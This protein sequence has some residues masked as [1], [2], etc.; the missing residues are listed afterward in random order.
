MP[1]TLTRPRPIDLYVGP[2][3]ATLSNTFL[4]VTTANAA[5]LN[6]FQV[7]RTVTV[8]TAHFRVGAQSG[9]LDFGIYDDSGT[10]LASTGSFACP[11]PATA[12]SSQALTSSVTLAPGRRYWA[13]IAAD[14]TTATLLG[15]GSAQSASA[16]VLGGNVAAT[17]P[18]P[19]SLTLPTT[20]AN[21][22]EFAV[23]YT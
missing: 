23:S 12:G 16:Y 22:R 8:S 21:R 19:A 1:P 2:S 11:A 3:G 17:F 6:A 9:N 18:L 10:R 5:Q 14:N 4:A 7:V 13:A 15:L 20:N